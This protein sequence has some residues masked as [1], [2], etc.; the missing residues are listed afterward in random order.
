MEVVKLNSA[1]NCF[2]YLIKSLEI[3]EIYIPYYLCSC[4]RH[5]AFSEGC[6]INFYHINKDFSPVCIF[7]KNSYILY[8]NYFGICSNIVKNL[9]QDYPNLIVDNSHSFYSKHTGIASFNSLRK[10]F[11]QIRDGGF[12][13]ITKNT[14]L[15]IDIDD[16]FYIPKNLDYS[17]VCK[18][19]Q[20][21]DNLEMK[22]MSDTT[23][24][25]FESI[26]LNRE[27]IKRRKNFE[28]LHKIYSDT[29]L[30]KINL[31]NE[32]VPFCYPYLA[33][34]NNDAD[35]LVNELTDRGITIYRYW[36]NMPEVYLENIFYKRLV[37]IP[38]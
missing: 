16:Y 23:Y 10:F 21:I 11:S 7:S 33:Q 18:N 32:D 19:E 31:D 28:K 37:A 4:I 24:N 27:K 13:Y 38:I 22:I 2:K 9:S 15:N 20:R 29:N 5:I 3:K 35:C 25:L 17:E 30:L 14:F 34:C 12:L 36:D 6:K 26:D 1:R 8:P